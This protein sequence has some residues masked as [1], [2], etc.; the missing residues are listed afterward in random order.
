M[1]ECRWNFKFDRSNYLLIRALLSLKYI[2]FTLPSILHQSDQEIVLG[3]HNLSFSSLPFVTV[4]PFFLPSI[5][6]SVSLWPFWDCH[7]AIIH[8]PSTP[9]QSQSELRS[10]CRAVASQSEL[11]SDPFAR[12]ITQ[13][14]DS[15]LWWQ[16]YSMG[17]GNSVLLTD[18]H[19]I[20]GFHFWKSIIQLHISG[21]VWRLP[22][23]SGWS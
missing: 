6:I 22:N 8:A 2:I 18:C 15:Q 20:I 5:D 1:V 19:S 9:F 14:S 12:N 11:L 17:N 7:R 16:C 21:K 10:E 3:L 13:Y 23:L 4:A